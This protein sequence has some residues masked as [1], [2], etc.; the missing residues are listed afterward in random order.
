MG[1]DAHD[2]T[3]RPE[4][5]DGGG[6]DV[7]GLV[8]ERPEPLVEEQGLEARGAFGRELDGLLREGERERERGEE[9]LASRKRPR[10][11]PLVGV[12][13]VH[14]LEV[15]PVVVLE[16]ILAARKLVEDRGRAADEPPERFLQKPALEA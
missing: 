12:A 15:Q 10:R 11:A 14:D 8:V 9:R 6:D 4:L 1:H 13:V 16:G 5:G 7:E 3:P 2:A